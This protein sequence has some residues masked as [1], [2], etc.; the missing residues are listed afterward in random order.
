MEANSSII[1]KVSFILLFLITIAFGAWSKTYTTANSGNWTSGSSWVGG[2]AP[3]ASIGNNDII[4]IYHTINLSGNLTINNN[5]VIHVYPSG[6]LTVSGNVV[7]N[8]NF[9]I[10]INEGGSFVVNGNFSVNNNTAGTID[11]LLQ[12]GGSLSAGNNGNVSGTG[13]ITVGGTTNDPNSTFNIGLFYGTTYYSW[14]SG[15]WNSTATWSF[16]SSSYVAVNKCPEYHNTVV[17]LSGKTVTVSASAQVKNLTINSG[18][19]LQIS[20]SN[21]LEVNGNWINNS[22]SGFL[23]NNTSTVSFAGTTA[24]GGS[25]INSFGNVSVQGVLTAPNAIINIAG[26]LDVSGT[27]NHNNGTVVFNGSEQTINTSTGVLTFKNL[28]INLGSSTR[29]SSNSKVSVLGNTVING[30]FI[31]ESS[32]GSGLSASF[33]NYGTITGTGT[34]QVQ[35]YLT[36][37]QSHYIS[38]PI[39]TPDLDAASNAKSNLFTSFGS[40]FNANFYMYDEVVDLDGKASTAPADYDPG[41]M[42]SGWKYMQKAANSPVVNM[43]N[44]KG[45]SFYGDI[46]GIRTFT[47][48]LNTGDMSVTGLSYTGNDPTTA[49]ARFYDGWHLVGNPYP[50]SIDWDAMSAGFNNIDQAF[51]VWDSENKRYNSYIAG[52]PGIGT[53]GQTNIIAP[54]QGFFVHSNSTNAGFTLN[55]THRVHANSA[56]TKFYSV[57]GGKVVS[58]SRTT[59]KRSSI[60]ANQNSLIKLRVTTNNGKSDEA[61]VYFRPDATEGYDGKFDAYAKFSW[62]KKSYPNYYNYEDIPNLFTLTNKDKMALSINALPDSVKDN[63]VVPIGLRLGTSGDVTISKSDFNI[64]NTNVYFVDKLTQIKTNLTANKDYTFKFTKGDVRDRFELQFKLNEAPVVADSLVDRQ[65][66]EN[67][68]FT[69][70]VPENTFVENDEGDMIVKYSAKNID[71]N[72]LPSWL[73]FDALTRTFLGKPG[74][75]DAGLVN[76]KVNAYDCSGA[77]A[78]CTFKLLINNVNNVPELTNPVSDKQI[79]EK[80]EFSFTLPDNTFIDKDLDD[81]L[82]FTAKLSNGNVLP[83]WLTFNVENKTFIGKPGNKDVGIIA[84]EI[85]AT[86]KS[87]ASISDA[88]SLEVLNVND[89]PVLVNQIPDQ[90]VN[91]NSSFSFVIPANKFEDI[92]LGDELSISAKLSN[93]NELPSWLTFS[94]ENKTFAGKPGKKDVGLVVIELL[95]TDRSGASVSTVFQL[96]VKDISGNEKSIDNK[97]LIYPNPTY[98]EFK[99][100]LGSQDL[101]NVEV[102]IRDMNMM[103]IEH[104]KIK[105]Q[106]TQFDVRKLSNGIYFI[107]VL[108]DGVIQKFKLIISK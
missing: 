20:G 29:L 60:V 45:Y 76:V 16:S 106:I 44:K 94:A 43:A 81:E 50:S 84:I 24:I 55:N 107:E 49:P 68:S 85:I 86:D 7:V 91:V 77:F 89:A 21:L 98:G 27:F 56:T 48:K 90:Q 6:A 95:A 83:T 104:Q 71:G 25:A 74:S 79:F 57:V 58:S 22:A 30:Q 92:D 8:N 26:N 23:A 15:N 38:S 9:N 63:L 12:I 54:I 11:G 53:N 52:S 67:E 82:N 34:S 40:S 66:S 28:T 59:Y 70:I 102:F 75:N 36:K 105:N 37:L 41:S 73:S 4:L 35:R 47:G 5:N 99:I 17:M 19:S 13:T 31:L 87:N 96:S 101:N 1:K 88:F 10:I 108:N 51:Y 72:E 33:I 14:T 103:P 97:V 61:I 78:S 69:F 65:Y 32:T 3:P 39:Q 2:T 62:N 100:D 18:A 42:S 64:S 93:G 80:N 46:S